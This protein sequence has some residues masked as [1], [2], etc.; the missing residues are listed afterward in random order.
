M[1]TSK[2][3]IR[4][5]PPDT[6]S[7]IASLGHSKVIPD[8]DTQPSNILFNE[9]IEDFIDELDT[10]AIISAP[11][12]D[13]PTIEEIESFVDHLNTIPTKCTASPII[14]DQPIKPKHHSNPRKA[15]RYIPL[16]AVVIFVGIL[17]V[18]IVIPMIQGSTCFLI[19]LSGSMAPSMS[20]GDVIISNHIDPKEVHLNDVITFTYADSPKKFV[21]H[22]VVNITTSEAVMIQFQTKGDANKEPDGRWVQSQEIVGKVTLVIPYLGYVSNFAKSKLGFLT[23]IIIPAILIISQGAWT[24]HKEQKRKKPS[25]QLLFSDSKQ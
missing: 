5:Y 16:A 22:R 7:T 11:S 6:T 10:T 12:S 2:K 1:M 25:H 17:L 18:T 20:P 9:K 14:N 21:T 24:I 23:I 4:F 3:R 15:A 19:V 8:L 13:E